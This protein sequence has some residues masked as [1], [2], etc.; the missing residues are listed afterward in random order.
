[1]TGKYTSKEKP[2]QGRLVDQAIYAK[3]YSNPSY[4]EIAEAFCAHAAQR[5][6]RPAP[7]ALAW[8]MANPAVTSPIF[9]A[10]NLEQMNDTL[11]AL[12][13]SMTPEW[14]AEI[15]AISPAPPDATDR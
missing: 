10:R 5:G 9:G 8:V 11:S 13:I 12:D 7:L 4:Y 2:E 15:A 3:R 6:V 14:Y 1:M